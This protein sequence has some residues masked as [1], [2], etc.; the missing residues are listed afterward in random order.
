MAAPTA[1]APGAGAASTGP[2]REAH[3]FDEAALLRYVQARGVP[4]L[5]QPPLALRVAQFGHGQSNPTF[6]LEVE[7]HD[8]V[9]K[10]VLRKKPPGLLLKSAHAVEREYQVLAAIAA[11]SDLPVPAVHC[12][13]T[14]PSV[15]G[16][17]FYI[18]TYIPGRIFTDPNLPELS[19]CERRQV[20]KEMAITLGK[21]HSVSI[22]SAGLASFGRPEDYCRRQ[23]ERWSQQYKL[24]IQGG[25][26]AEPAM[27]SL[28]QWL[29][30]NVP[31]EDSKSGGQTGLV[32]GDYRLD[33]LVFH[34][35]ELRVAA[36]L[37]WELSTLGNQM[38]DVAYSCM[39][40]HLPAGSPQAA[41]LVREGG[42]LPQGI[43]SEA[44]YIADYCSA[45]TKRWPSATWRFY[46]ALSLFRAASIFAGVYKRALQ[47]NASSGNAMQAG[48]LVKVLAAIGLEII[49][50]DVSLP[51]LPPTA[52]PAA[53]SHFYAQP[54]TSHHSG[55]SRDSQVSSLPHPIAEVPNVSSVD[56]STF[57]KAST[58]SEHNSQGF[59]PSKRVLEIRSKLLAFMKREVYP[60]EEVLEAHAV[61]K[62]KWTVHPL[63]EDLKQKARE[64]GLWNLWIPA[65]S[66]VLARE[67]AEGGAS[68]G[69]VGAGLSNE[70]YAHLCE[71]MGRSHWAP[72]LFNCSAPDTGNME[73]LLRYGNPVQ[74][75][76]WLK[77][78]LEGSIRSCFAMTEPAVASSDA[79][80]IQSSI[81]RKGD[82][83]ILNGRKWWTSGAMDPRCHVAIFMG[84][85]DTKAAVHKQQSMVLVDM[86]SPGVR[87]LR[88]LTVFGFEDAPHGHAEVLFENV[89]VPADNLLL[90]EGRGF[91]IAQG[92][93]GPG[94]L[95]HCMRLVGACERGIELMATRALARTAFGRPLARHGGFAATLAECRVDIE[96]ARCLVLRAAHDLDRHGNKGAR[97]SIAIAKVVAPRAAQKV[98]DA[99]M[100]V[101]G[102]GGLSSDFPLAHLWATA[103]TLRIADGPD[104]VH[105]GTIA[106]SELA[107]AARL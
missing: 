69:L 14:D 21:L 96:A 60:N 6:L 34:P 8:R 103:R 101:H 87:V 63:V 93:L 75:R 90:G 7:G 12:L 20:Y 57:G 67:L 59:R 15:I 55:L 2:V 68:E 39:P 22:D 50:K 38:S 98:L 36:V 47:G 10:Y 31:A 77:P 1:A 58:S 62:T 5:P 16:T 88:P 73:V 19:A 81:V 24:S 52:L 32:H 17:P 30:R 84:K 13:C 25:P 80:N 91:E 61:S 97:D 54:S 46:M 70:E 48:A 99:A 3:R 65:D 102:A 66:A 9:A 104:E 71:V 45:A 33:N 37:D 76:T 95:H 83:Y 35:T 42:K 43:P 56:N 94:R 53:L 107:K 27:L 72:E 11:S 82:D 26:A 4:G 92:R 18:M 44:E 41:A 49:E 86:H 79:T 40:Y 64:A 85:T 89:V 105:L 78:L 28:S 29:Q 74:Q 106:R 23:V 100:Q 51:R